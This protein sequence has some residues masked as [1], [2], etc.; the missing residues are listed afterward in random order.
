MRRRA[1]RFSRCWF[2]RSISQRRGVERFGV[3]GV[4]H[5]RAGHRRSALRFHG[6]PAA[7]LSRRG[8]RVLERIGVG[9]AAARRGAGPFACPSSDQTVAGRRACPTK[10]AR[11]QSLDTV[12][13]GL[14]Y[15]RRNPL[16]LGAISLDLFAVLLG[17]AVALL[18]AYASDIL[19]IGPEGPGPAA[20]RARRRAP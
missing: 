17:G 1:R 18:P 14:R 15:I 20:Q 11:P 9:V 2:E 3:H 6:Q 16:L 10:A 4:H 19:K 13:E 12:L 7:G 8:G 5:S